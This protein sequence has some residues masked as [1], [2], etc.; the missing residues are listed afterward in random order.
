MSLGQG[1]RGPPPSWIC[2]SSV[3]VN[4]LRK[5]KHGVHI[6]YP[7]VGILIHSVGAMFVDDSDLY[8]R[9]E[10]KIRGDLLLSTGGCLKQEANV[11]GIC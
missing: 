7:M 6:V 8:Y 10:T 1:N 4:I 2:L 9:A 5:L 3:I 11:S